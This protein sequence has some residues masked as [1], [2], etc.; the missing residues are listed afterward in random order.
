[1]YSVGTTLIRRKITNGGAIIPIGGV[2][3]ILTQ[4][5]LDS[6]R[7]DVEVVRNCKRPSGTQVWACLYDDFVPLNLILKRKSL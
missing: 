6:T 2:I 1:M 5:T 3:K 4:L 7:C